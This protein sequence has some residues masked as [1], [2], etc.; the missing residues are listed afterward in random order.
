MLNA[1]GP[2]VSV[3]VPVYNMAAYVEKCL[4]SI[5]DASCE[6][7]ELIV[8]DDGSTD[9]SLEICQRKLAGR[10]DVKILQQTN[11]GQ[12]AARNYGLSVATGRYVLF[13]DSDDSID[14]R[15]FEKTVPL[16]EEGEFDFVSFGLDFVDLEGAVS[17]LVVPR[18][19]KVLEG[20][21]IFE[22]A[23]MDEEIYSSPVNKLYSRDFLIRHDIRFPEIKACEDV[24]FSRILSF[25]STATAFISEVLYHALV[26]PGS[27]TR[28]VGENFLKAT[29]DVLGREKRYL[30]EKGAFAEYRDLYMRHYAKQVAYVF[31]VLS[32]RAASLR[33]LGDSVRLAREQ[34]DFKALASSGNW[35]QVG[36]KYKLFLAG[37]RF[38]VLLRGAAGVLSI[39]NVRPY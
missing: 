10:S 29:L 36:L 39:F 15:V 5:L 25:N 12:G 31:Y 33:V 16:M 11:A 24:Y 18:K 14:K 22:H 17:H 35:A 28:N 37:S 7:L 4:D 21:A 27:T 30:Q 23:M 8:V 26:R 20:R 9:K 3:I 34:E 13:V 38:P 19:Y 32:Y 2:L 6:R 1:Q